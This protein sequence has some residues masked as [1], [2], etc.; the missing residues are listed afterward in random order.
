[1]VEFNHP[2]SRNG[3]LLRRSRRAGKT[4]G[5]HGF[6]AISRRQGNRAANLIVTVKILVNVLL[7]NG[8]NGAWPG[9]QGTM[10]RVSGKFTRT[11]TPDRLCA[12][13][14][15]SISFVEPSRDFGYRMHT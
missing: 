14:I 1:M 2:P 7:V 8:Y 11:R 12:P 15:S 4:P 13:D 3:F 6:Q 9:E 10:H 5:S